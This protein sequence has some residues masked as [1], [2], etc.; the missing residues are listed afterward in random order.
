MINVKLKIRTLSRR[1]FSTSQAAALPNLTGRLGWD[2]YGPFGS[3]TG[4]F[5][6]TGGGRTWPS[7]DGRGNNADFDASRISPVYKDGHDEVTPH[8]FNINGLIKV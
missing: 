2:G 1:P 3:A 8:N 6:L 5:R 4:A 7:Q